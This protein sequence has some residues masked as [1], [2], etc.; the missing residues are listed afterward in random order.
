MVHNEVFE[1]VSLSDLSK[2]E[3]V[4]DAT[5]AMKKKSSRILRGRVNVQ[6]FKQIDGQHYN[7]TSISAPVGSQRCQL[8]QHDIVLIQLAALGSYKSV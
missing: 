1:P 7:W 5:W 2:N 4:I 3:K 6:G 8:Y